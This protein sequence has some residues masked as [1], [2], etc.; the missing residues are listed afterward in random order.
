MNPLLAVPADFAA[1]LQRFF[2]ERLIQQQNASPRTVASYRDTFRLLL[3]YA[4]REKGKPPAKLALG[5][6][7]TALVLDF[8]AHL[9]TERH[10]SV[11]SRNVRLA[12]VRAFAHY[13]ALQYPPALQ[14]AQQILAIPMKRFEKPLLGF[15]SRDEIQALLAA[16]D[17][18]TW[19]GRRDRVMFA[20][21]YNTGARVSEMIGIKVADVT[22]A[23]TSSVRLHGKGRKQRTV[24][25]WKETAAEIRDWLKYMDL[26][27]DQSLVPNRSGLPMTRTNVADRLTLAITT[28]TTQCPQLAGRMISPHSI[29]HTTAMHLLQAGVDITVIALWL[30]H[31]SPVTTH[32]YVEADLAMKERALATIAPPE[33]KRKRYR[34]SDAV[35]KFLEGL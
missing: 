18:G 24:P 13:V 19:C 1:L 22:L 6:F 10:N 30:G 33:T 28:A 11:R 14:L 8:L 26:R 9:E 23:V 3:S 17:A 7:D 25:L 5:D 27:A 15:L 35:L 12:A 20:L 31:E 34:P 29:R 16:P 4:E 2:G 32:G 21:L